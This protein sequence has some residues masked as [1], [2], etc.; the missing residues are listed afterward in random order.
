MSKTP[1]LE[2]KQRK[3]PNSS[4]RQHDVDPTQEPFHHHDSWDLPELDEYE[5]PKNQN[6][7]ESASNSDP[8]QAQKNT[9][10]DRDDTGGG[11]ANGSVSLTSESP[12]AELHKES[13]DDSTSKRTKRRRS[14]CNFHYR[15]TQGGSSNVEQGDDPAMQSPGTSIKALKLMEFVHSDQISDLD[16]PPMDK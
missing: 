1:M 16:M 3:N 12:S 14:F 10:V 9:E 11:P 15:T 8:G 6:L 2:E 7:D 5:G 13:P 4:G